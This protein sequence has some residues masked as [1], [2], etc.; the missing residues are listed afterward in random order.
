[1]L[2][3]K[4]LQLLAC[5]SGVRVERSRCVLHRF[6]PAGCGN[7]F[8]ACPTGA[9]RWGDE[10]LEWQ[11]AECRRCFLCVAACPSGALGVRDF[12]LVPQLRSLGQQDKP[13]LSCSG[14]PESKGHARVPCLGLMSDPEL[15]LV[16]MLA[17][18]KP[19]QLN[20]T[21][22]AT[23]PNNAVIAPLSSVLPLVRDLIEEVRLV[24]AEADLD[25]REP[26]VSRRELFRILRSKS[27][28]VAGSL[29]DSLQSA[30]AKSYGD[31]VIPEARFLLLQL[32]GKLSTERRAELS[33]RIFP[34]IE[35][36]AFCSGCTGCVGLCPTG[37]LLP[38]ST[39]GT[40]P[41]PHPQNCT[42]CGLCT[43]FCR[44]EAIRI[45]SSGL[46]YGGRTQIQ[47]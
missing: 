9:I 32:L 12:A 1:M 47:D 38:P 37:A 22:C 35:I 23:C 10:G 25:H 43:A 34:T 41:T 21:H 19:L 26:G 45:T 14:M 24:T 42:E 7:C 31:K 15:L 13:V 17:V 39:P 18:G 44:T 16:T 40:P 11:E 6:K 36:K 46:A 3:G 28:E 20:M 8:A 30:P 4:A 2:T 33:A 29:A 5:Q 27:R